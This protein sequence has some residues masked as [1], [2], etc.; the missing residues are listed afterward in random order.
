M[1]IVK[2]GVTAI[3]RISFVVHD[4]EGI[5]YPSGDLYSPCLMYMCG[6]AYKSQDPSLAACPQKS[7]DNV[8]AFEVCSI[9][10]R[11]V[12]I[13]VRSVNIDQRTSR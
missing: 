4:R 10:N 1:C 5:V 6:L 8:A 11:N 3:R 9:G 2:P 7:A 13:L 12:I